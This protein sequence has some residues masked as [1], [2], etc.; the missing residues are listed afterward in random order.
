MPPFFFQA[1]EIVKFQVPSLVE[2]LIW[3]SSKLTMSVGISCLARSSSFFGSG[4]LCSTRVG[5]KPEHIGDILES[6]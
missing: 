5:E 1:E 4:D 6:W 2:V 3:N